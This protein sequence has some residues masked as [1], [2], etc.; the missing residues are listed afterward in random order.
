[1]HVDK[2][3]ELFPQFMR[4]F[5]HCDVNAK[6]YRQ[7]AVQLSRVFLGLHEDLDSEE[8]DDVYASQR[9]H[10][11]SMAVARYGIE[12][13][14]LA[15]LSSDDL[16]RFGRASEAWWTVSDVHPTAPAC[17]PVHTRNQIIRTAAGNSGPI[18]GKP[19]QSAVSADLLIDLKSLFVAEFQKVQLALKDEILG[20]VTAA[21]TGSAAVFST[22]SPSTRRLTQG[23]DSFIPFSPPSHP[24]SNQLDLSGY[25]QQAELR[26]RDL[27]LLRTLFRNTTAQFKTKHQ[28][29]AVELSVS[30]RY[31][32][33]AVLPTGSGKSLT[34]LL[35]PLAEKIQGIFTIVVVPNKSLLRTQE[36]NARKFGLNTL[37]WLT[38][39]EGILSQDVQLVFMAVESITTPT[40]KSFW[41][42]HSS[43]IARLVVDEAHQILSAQ[44]YRT[45]FLRIRDLALL[46][47]PKLFLTASLPR[48]WEKDF[49]SDTNMLPTTTIVRAP[50]NQLHISY[51]VF[52]Y[53]SNSISRSAF[54][55]NLIPYISTKVLAEK[56]QGIIFV[57][58]QADAKKFGAVLNCPF[59]YSEMPMVE[60]DLN[61]NKSAKYWGSRIRRNPYGL[62]NIYQGAG[63]GG[64]DGR[65]SWA[66]M[67]NDN[68]TLQIKPRKGDTDVECIRESEEMIKQ[69]KC[70]RIALSRTLDGEVKTCA[71][72]KDC[73]P[74]DVCSPGLSI[75]SDINEILQSSNRPS[76]PPIPNS[77][78]R[79]IQPRAAPVDELEAFHAALDATLDLA[80]LPSEDIQFSLPTSSRMSIS[81]STAAQSNGQFS[82]SQPSTLPSSTAASSPSP[83][84]YPAFNST[85][86]PRGVK[87]TLE[88]MMEQQYAENRQRQKY[89]K[90]QGL[91]EFDQF[92]HGK[93]VVCWLAGAGFR[94][95]DHGCNGCR[96]Q[97][98]VIRPFRNPL[99]ACWDFKKAM[100]L[101]K[102]QYCFYCGL[103]QKEYILDGHEVFQ[104]GVSML[105]CSFEDLHA[106]ILFHIRVTPYIWTQ[107][108]DVFST[109]RMAILQA[110]GEKKFT[111]MSFAQWCE[112][113]EDRSVAFY[114]GLELI[115]W[116]LPIIQARIQQ[117]GF[118]TGEK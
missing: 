111:W 11:H 106:H 72:L 88:T 19:I 32:I 118:S 107:A 68:K 37:I 81:S 97:E 53:D 10:S 96:G 27:Q 74:C 83:H 70:R 55:S 93:C 67:L 90:L 114:N 22:Q 6:A 20:S 15:M 43:R 108:Q 66:F 41:A 4:D 82:S 113:E 64:R 49:L 65:R 92:I 109:L 80:A 105:K 17:L 57:T 115:I 99:K 50:S 116:A 98:P 13:G 95:K 28:A 36:A 33:I 2:V 60:R 12:T 3:R 78:I 25:T 31:S 77:P 104:K 91:R 79:H 29:L 73:H 63:R 40:F 54:I 51:S 101:T 38:H 14:R 24:F 9:G 18:D 102:Y 8:V 76:P 47:V 110:G 1:M 87:R 56:Q 112:R 59:T 75:W 84:A 48:Q 21:L 26:E 39:M 58:S 62:L 117:F 71:D 45:S 52:H 42:S 86:G 89:E 35:P 100:R 34:Y 46:A 44:D 23:V 7:I 69:H 16:L 85:L 94:A 103:P 30:N 61:E 5:C